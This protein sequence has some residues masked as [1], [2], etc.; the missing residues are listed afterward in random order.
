MESAEEARRLAAEVNQGAQ[1]SA[2]RAL[3]ALQ[4]AESLRSR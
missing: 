3:S 1:A 2:E 4:R